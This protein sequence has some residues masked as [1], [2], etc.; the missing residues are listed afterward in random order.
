M[1]NSI[2]H[3]FFELLKSAIWG[4]TPKLKHIP[5]EE[6]WKD[7][8]RISN[9]Q[10]VTGIML[11]AISKLPDEQKPESKLRLQWIVTQKLIERK[12]GLMN[13][14]L[15]VLSEE[16]KE[17]GIIS[18]LL[19]G[20]GVAQSYPIPE[21]RVSGDI[22]Y[23]FEERYFKAASDFFSSKGCIIE[24]EPDASHAETSYKGTII[25]IHR[26]SA[27]F[28][29]KRL[30]KRYDEISSEIIKDD[31]ESIIIGGNE[32]AVLPPML[33]ALQLLSHMLRHIL[34]SGLGLR[35]ICDWV[36]FVYNYQRRIDK[37][38]FIAQIKELQLY[39]TYKAITAIATDYLG[40]PKEYA[41]C[42]ISA[43]DK[44][45][46]KKVMV[47]IMQYG[48][49]GHYK[50]HY[51]TETKW[52]YFKA[53]IRLVKNSIYFT[54]LSRSEALNFPIWQMRSIKKVLKH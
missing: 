16:L 32:I 21:H 36:L 28:F 15:V 23:Y 3:T 26:R 37:E 40:L 22:D 2:E 48:N 51:T 52:E 50:E 9:E 11:D 6:E 5:T 4:T 1:M 30:Q 14:E 33:N 27:T 24:D 19:K 45:I 43:K 18:Y 39:N 42:E 47:H 20:Q 31:K 8:Y 34:M 29:T 35:Q 53:Y 12:N 7:I 17:K 49:F 46:A 38:L 54:C 25:E 13:K 10:T 44:A 41:V